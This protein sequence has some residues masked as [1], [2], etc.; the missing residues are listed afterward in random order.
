MLRAGFEPAIPV[1]E[2]SKAVP[3]ID[4]SVYKH[5]ENEAEVSEVKLAY[6]FGAPAL[7]SPWYALTPLE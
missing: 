7:I 5:V 6:S 4:R 1:F 2:W 3:S